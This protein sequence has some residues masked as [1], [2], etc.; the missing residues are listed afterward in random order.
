MISRGP[1]EHV[2]TVGEEYT[3]IGMPQKSLK[4]LAELSLISRLEN[5]AL[6]AQYSKQVS[7]WFSYSCTIQAAVSVIGVSW[8]FCDG[9]FSS[10]I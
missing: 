1:H 6:S 8:M 5:H 10:F 3:S 9:L 2:K 4:T 7:L